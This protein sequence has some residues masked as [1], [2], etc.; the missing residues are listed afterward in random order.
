MRRLT[1]LYDLEEL[2]KIDTELGVNIYSDGLRI[3]TTIDSRVQKILESSFEK[4]IQKNQKVLN[5]EFI[6]NPQKLR[7]AIQGT[8]YTENEIIDILKENGTIPSELRSKLLV[9]GAVIAINPKNGHILGMIGGRQEEEYLD[10]HGFNR[11]TQAKR[12]PGS[13][14]KPFNI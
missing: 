14:F 6:N 11:A 10:L 7:K 2:E 5:Q 9:Q 4:N 13:I 1:V 3:H 8:D 12:Q